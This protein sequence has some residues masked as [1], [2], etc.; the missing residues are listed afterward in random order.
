MS[1]RLKQLFDKHLAG[2]LSAEERIELMGLFLE[3][4]L[5]SQLQELV[6]DAWWV[7]GEDTGMA[8]DRK[9]ALLH[10]VLHSRDIKA[11]QQEPLEEAMEPPVVTMP[12]ARELGRR[13]TRW[14]AAAS[15]LLVAGATWW[16]MDQQARKSAQVVVKQDVEAPKTNRARVTLANGQVVDLDSMNNGQIALQGTVQLV[17]LANGQIAYKNVQ[18]ELIAEMQFNTLENPRGSKV[19]SMTLADGSRVWLN[20]GSSVTYPVA[21]AGNERKVAISGEAY[22]EVAH[23][24]TKPFYVTKGNTQVQVLGTHFNINAYD[25][26]PATRVTLLEGAVKV[27]KETLTETLRPGQQAQVAADIKVTDAVNVEAVMAWKN[28]LFS[29]RGT[30]LEDMMRQIAR[31]YDM[32]VT[33]KGAIPERQFGGKIYRDANISRVLEILEESN[34]HYQINN[35]EIVIMP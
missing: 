24:A 9:E 16:W 15:V 8:A 13:W 20:A 28:G 33:Y 4:S 6:K 3:S 22:F 35:K 18:G 21:F 34:I 7:T 2:D 23:D 27:S 31:W 11:A 32:K 5:Q 26:E 1:E 19:I 12:V 10:S 17:K 25:D 14:L 29:F 30:S